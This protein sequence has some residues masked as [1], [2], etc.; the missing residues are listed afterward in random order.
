MS[1][2]S[3]RKTR[4]DHSGDDYRTNSDYNCRH[5]VTRKL[6][7][8]RQPEVF[9]RRSRAPQQQR[10]PG[11]T[12]IVQPRRTDAYSATAAETAKKQATLTQIDFVSTPP[13]RGGDRRGRDSEADETDSDEDDIVECSPLQYGVKDEDDN[14][15]DFDFDEPAPPRKKA[16]RSPPERA[17]STTARAARARAS[18]RAQSTLTQAWDG[19]TPGLTSRPSVISDS[20]EDVEI[21]SV[22]APQ[23]PELI[24]HQH[25]IAS[26]KKS[27]HSRR[28]AFSPDRGITTRT[29][30]PTIKSEHVVQSL[31]NPVAPS[32]KT[33]RTVRWE[34]PSSQTPASIKLSAESSPGLRDVLNRSPLGKHTPN[35][36]RERIVQETCASEITLEHAPSRTARKGSPSQV[37]AVAPVTLAQSSV[38]Q[39]EQEGSPTPKK[40]TL[41]HIFTVADSDDEAEISSASRTGDQDQLQSALEESLRLRDY[42]Q[43]QPSNAFTQYPQTYDP[44][45]AALD[46]DAARYEDDTPTQSYASARKATQDVLRPQIKPNRTPTGKTRANAH[47]TAQS[48]VPSSPIFIHRNASDSSLNIIISSSAPRGPESED[49]TLTIPDSPHVIG[50]VTPRIRTSQMS[51]VVP[52][53]PEEFLARLKSARKDFDDEDLPGETPRRRGTADRPDQQIQTVLSSSPIPLPPWSEDDMQTRIQT[54]GFRLDSDDLFDGSLPPPPPGWSEAPGGGSDLNLHSSNKKRR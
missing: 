21:T 9:S 8:M 52:S 2:I 41:R 19:S 11:R 24:S 35:P 37:G 26:P 4:E 38:F 20:D 47:S 39:M 51:T 36:Q 5:A 7:I 40:P 10:F 12:S 31:S 23:S 46:R 49:A 17:N 44:V 6:I 16:K 13:V 50:T 22:S 1:R 42:T 54:R 28:V 3:E 15:D 53:S 18:A 32:P 29:T 45:N 30:D 14:P 25:R 27:N 48:L 33:P 34:V 43:F